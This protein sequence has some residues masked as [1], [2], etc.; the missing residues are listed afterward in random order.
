M[1]KYDINKLKY[2]EEFNAGRGLKVRKNKDGTSTFLLRKKMPKAKAPLGLSLGVYPDMS[3]DEAQA[4]AVTYRNLI[5]DGID[6]RAWEG[7]QDRIREQEEAEEQ[8]KQTT[9]R[10]ALERYNQ[11]CVLKQPPNAP[12]TIQD[13]TNAIQSVFREFLDKP[14][15]D[16]TTIDIENKL[17]QWAGQGINSPAQGRK[18]TRYLRSILNYCK[19][20]LQ[21]IPDNPVDAF[22]NEISLSS[23]LNK[24]Y[25]QI[26]EVVNMFDTLSQMDHPEFMNEY[27]ECSPYEFGEERRAMFDAI[28]LQAL[29]GLRQMEVL[30]LTW[31]KVYL[32]KEQ[33]EEE[34][35]GDADGAYFEAWKSKTRSYFGVPITTSM[36]VIFLRR[37]RLTK[38]SKY[39]FPSTKRD[40]NGEYTYIKSDRRAYST[41]NK[42][43]PKPRK[44]DKYNANLMRHTF[45]DTAHKIT[46]NMDIVHSMTGHFSKLDDGKRATGRYIAF[47]SASNRT[48]FQQVN[49]VLLDIAEPPEEID[50]LPNDG[51]FGPVK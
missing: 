14:V 33:W 9:L 13:R 50:E 36:E 46:R 32:E 35:E 29:S 34:G 2:Q 4:K 6:P 16:I 18:A 3:I 25:L 23:S 30:S 41:L 28:A 48:Y 49:D 44:A 15:R 51:P 40:K 1:K 20:R 5:S 11:V 19:R 10:N 26:P 22:Q 37:K 43:L 39:V 42:I 8:A 38:G 24:I 45:A 17:M 21:V 47:Q 7:E 31:D 12:R 27:P